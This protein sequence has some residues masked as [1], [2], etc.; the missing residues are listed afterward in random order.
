MDHLSPPLLPTLLPHLPWATLPPPHSSKDPHFG[1]RPLHGLLLCQLPPSPDSASFPGASSS[2]LTTCFLGLFWF[3]LWAKSVVYT[4]NLGL[5]P[6]FRLQ[7][8]EDFSESE[9]FLTPFHQ[10]NPT[11]SDPTPRLGETRRE[12]GLAPGEWGGGSQLEP[13]PCVPAG[14]QPL[15]P[16]PSPL[17]GNASFLGG[18]EVARGGGRGPPREWGHLSLAALPQGRGRGD[19]GAAPAREGCCLGKG[20]VV[21]CPVT[22][23]AP[24]AHSPARKAWAP[25][26]TRPCHPSQRPRLGPSLAVVPGPAG[27]S[28]C[29]TSA[30]RGPGA[31]WSAFWGRSCPHSQPLSPLLPCPRRPFPL[32]WLAGATAPPLMAP[33]GA[34]LPGSPPSFSFPHWEPLDLRTSVP[35]EMPASPAFPI[36][37]LASRTF[38]GLRPQPSDQCSSMS[39]PPSAHPTLPDPP[40]LATPPP[41]TAAPPQLSF[42]LCLLCS[43]L[44]LSRSLWD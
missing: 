9:V 28:C 44:A 23:A 29:P 14:P 41:L 39:P 18:V 32:P 31:P 33:P 27:P 24:S 13:C 25:P 7:A 8:I 12:G 26:Q 4:L 36:P 35:G 42:T 38:S 2:P 11:F 40:Q 6:L 37:L 30:R 21:Y 3:R 16:I 34:L 10:K 22:S 43:A 1:V 17:T 19:G 15:F 20:P 5:L